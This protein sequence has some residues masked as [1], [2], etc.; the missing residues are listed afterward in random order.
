MSASER[1]EEL[2][3]WETQCPMNLSFQPGKE[4]P[5]HY[6]MHSPHHDKKIYKSFPVWGES[7]QTLASDERFTSRLWHQEHKDEIHSRKSSSTS[8]TQHYDSMTFASFNSHIPRQSFQEGFSWGN[9]SHLTHSSF[10]EEESFLI[11]LEGWSKISCSRAS[12]G[13]CETAALQR[14]SIQ[15]WGNSGLRPLQF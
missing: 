5:D 11:Y 8:I 13:F 9:T 6:S 12:L 1:P 14:A 7:T 2:S 3:P 15:H 4:L 10:Y